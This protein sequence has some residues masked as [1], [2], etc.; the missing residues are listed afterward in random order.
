MKNALVRRV[1][2]LGRIVI[3]KDFRKTID[4]A[5]GERLEISLNEN[6][7]IVLKKKDS[8]LNIEKEIKNIAKQ[9]AG[10]VSSG[11]VICSLNKIIASK[12]DFI[13]Y[14]GK[15]ISKELSDFI[16]F[17]QK[18]IFYYNQPPIIK[19]DNQKRR[20][21]LVQPIS[22][23]GDP[24]GALVL[25]ADKIEDYEIK[26]IEFASKLIENGVFL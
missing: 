8:F 7:E 2:E 1:D 11:F 21:E 20:L 14:V 25:K 19:E 17:N 9:L 6:D 10:F 26:L 15:N 18:K 22:F 13:D 3:P 12:K 16:R 5:E 23:D 4:I 24:I